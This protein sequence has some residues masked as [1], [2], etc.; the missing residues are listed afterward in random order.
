MISE[1]VLQVVGALSPDEQVEL[2]D[3]L[4]GELSGREE[5][6]DDVKRMLDERLAAMEADPGAGQP[7]EK[8]KNE[9]RGRFRWSTT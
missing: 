7:W 1:Q 6:T 5:L 2:I 3:H 9:L 4:Q 8:V